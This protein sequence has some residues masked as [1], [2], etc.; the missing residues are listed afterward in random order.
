MTMKKKLITIIVG[1]LICAELLGG[2]GKK[3]TNKDNTTTDTA[4]ES[5]PQDPDKNQEL[6]A[7]TYMGETTPLRRCAGSLIWPGHRM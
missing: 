2:C 6:P 1:M 3:D 7:A 4:E 5:K